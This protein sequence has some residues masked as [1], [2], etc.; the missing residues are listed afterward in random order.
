MLLRSCESSA[1]DTH[2]DMDLVLRRF[3]GKAALVILVAIHGGLL[4]WAGATDSPTNDEPFH[5]T[6]GIRRTT[7][8]LFDVDRGAPLLPSTVAAIP[9]VFMAPETDWRR[10][11]DCFD[12]GRD[13]LKANGARSFWLITVGRWACV[14]FSLLGGAVCWC[15]ARE[16]NGPAAGFLAAALWTFCPNTIAYGH[17]ITGD[18]AATSCGVLAVYM[19]WRWLRQ[20]T[21]KWA[22]AAGLA[23]GAALL[24][25]HVLLVLLAL[26]PLLW[27]AWLFAPRSLER[28]GI[29]AQLGHLAAMA[30]VSLSVV[31]LAFLYR[32]TGEP[33]ARY[34]FAR[35]WIGVAETPQSAAVAGLRSVIARLPAPLPED[36][37][38]AIDEIDEFYAGRN[39]ESYLRGEWK[40]DGWWYYYPYAALVK[41]PIGTL[42]VL[43]L[44]AAL[45]LRWKAPLSAGLFN[46]LALLLPIVAI[47]DI[48]TLVTTVQEHVRYVLPALPFALI[49]ASKVA[50]TELLRNRRVAVLVGAC[51]IGAI[52]ESMSVYPH[53]L[54]FFNCAAGGPR[55]GHA[56]LLGSG[57]DWGQGLFYL[58]EWLD[59]HPDARPLHL[60][61]QGLVDPKMVGIESVS[62]PPGRSRGG[63]ALDLPRRELGPQP[64]WHAVC[65]R[66]LRARPYD[67]LLMFE[68]ETVL[69]Y[70]FYIYHLTDDEVAGVRKKLGLPPVKGGAS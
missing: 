42:C 48:V 58:K 47:F 54:A 67:Y 6:G 49:W 29:P 8:G 63:K 31:N 7:Q 1:T 66:E 2:C 12:L 68:P 16:L 46:E 14:P 39:S 19:F 64:G 56:H 15:W 37:L 35:R 59:A 23:L 70:S 25:K 3:T 13:F 33:L 32:G 41:T 62:V 51:V 43:G 21:I 45:S 50:R 55:N 65:Q 61:Y 20:P 27:I 11:S 4:A 52:V 40:A 28:R 36:Y 5:L 60:V 17:I 34:K 57:G 24:T 30:A 53:S 38:L 26:Y 69:G 18:A 44:A 22:L 10:A 9:V